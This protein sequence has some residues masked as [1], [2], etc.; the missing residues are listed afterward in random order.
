MARE[1]NPD[2]GSKIETEEDGDFTITF[3]MGLPT[4]PPANN[5]EEN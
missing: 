1:T 3:S 4:P 5:T 2:T